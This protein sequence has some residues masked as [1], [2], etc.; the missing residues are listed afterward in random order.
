MVD[1]YM[2]VTSRKELYIYKGLK[3]M[4]QRRETRVV[5]LLRVVVVVGVGA[6]DI[7]RLC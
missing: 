5:T 7:L 2:T 3:D 4:D 1:R 6:A